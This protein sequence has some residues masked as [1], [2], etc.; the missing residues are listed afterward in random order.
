MERPAPEALIAYLYST[1]GFVVHICIPYVW[2]VLPWVTVELLA[3]QHL[4]IQGTGRGRGSQLNVCPIHS[5]PMDPL[6]FVSCVGRGYPSGMND[7]APTYSDHLAQK[8]NATLVQFVMKG[9][10]VFVIN[11]TH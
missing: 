10:N 6:P 4:C 5:D 9:L 1:L 3:N 11:E 2:A 7:A 8:Q